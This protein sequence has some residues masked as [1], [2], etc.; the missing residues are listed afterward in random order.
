MPRVTHPELPGVALL[1]QTTD[2]GYRVENEHNR[3]NRAI[4]FVPCWHEWRR[5]HNCTMHCGSVTIEARFTASSRSSDSH[6]DWTH[7]YRASNS[8]VRGALY[9]QDYGDWTHLYRASNIRVRGA[10][11]K[12]LYVQ[13]GVTRQGHFS[14]NHVRTDH[15][16]F[17]YI[18][19]PIFRA[20]VFVVI[21][22]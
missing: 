16:H 21:R 2:Y 11:W 8:R 3:H 6:R 10:L 4:V 7:L 15:V 20:K 18:I 13:D 1:R 22:F 12:A 9:V 17:M 19:G 14:G 5:L